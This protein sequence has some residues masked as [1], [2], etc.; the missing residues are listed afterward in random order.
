M[1]I[2][3]FLVYKKDSKKISMVTCYDYTSACLL[4]QTPIDCVLVGDS[5]A[6]T[7]FGFKTTLQATVTMMALQTSAVSKAF[8]DFKSEK[9]LVADMPFLAHRMGL[10]Q[11]IKNV[12]KLMQAGAHAV[13]IEGAGSNISVIK[14]I[15]ESGV[16]V[17]GHLGLTPQ[18]FYQLGGN[19]VQAKRQEE[20]KKLLADALALQDAGC[21]ALV[22]ECVPRA[23]AKEVSLSLEI[24]TIGIGA[25]KETDGQVLVWQ[26]LLGLNETFKPKFLRKFHTLSSEVKTALTNYHKNVIEKKFPEDHESFE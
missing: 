9:F 19:K 23:I 3:D 11:T 7:M 6:M 13:K 15:V 26:D 8:D 4:A 16:P 5:S 24:P 12:Q 25:G 14:Y 1:K 18:S 21:F 17:M 10:N 22:L 2:Q 20:Q